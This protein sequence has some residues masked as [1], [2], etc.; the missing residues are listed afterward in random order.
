MKEPEWER[1]PKHFTD[2]YNLKMLDK[3]LSVKGWNSGTAEFMGSVLQFEVCFIPPVGRSYKDRLQ[4]KLFWRF[5]FI[6]MP[7]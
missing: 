3:E 2:A 1:L 6:I 7:F 4:E 5:F